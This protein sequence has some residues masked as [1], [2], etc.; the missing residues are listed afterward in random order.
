MRL[1]HPIWPPALLAILVLMVF[2]DGFWGV[3]RA[4]QL[5]YLYEAAQFPRFID[6]LAHAP[7]WNRS[8]SVGDY[9]LFRPILYL[10]LTVEYGLFG[11]N[12]LLWQ[13]TGIALHAA[14]SVALLRLFQ[15]ASPATT[16]LNLIA[17]GLFA[18]LLISSEAVIWH[19]ISA[20]IL[21]ALCTTGS[22]LCLLRYLETNRRRSA[23]VAVLLAIVATFTYELG[24]VYCLLVAVSLT[25]SAG[26]SLVT[27]QSDP[28]HPP[29]AP[30]ARRTLALVFAAIPV[31]YVAVSLA[32]FLAQFRGAPALGYGPG[33]SP[34]VG[35]GLAFA[36]H[37]I[38]FWLGGAILPTVYDITWGGGRS[39]FQAYRWSSE[40]LTLLNL[41]VVHITAV[42][43]L[44]W[45]LIGRRHL[46]PAAA[47]G[48]ALGGSLLFAYS[49]IISFGRSVP[50]GLLTLAINLH[51]A[52]IAMVLLAATI[53]VALWMNRTAPR[54]E[55][56]ARQAG[57]PLALSRRLLLVGL[58][59][60]L[61]VNGVATRSLLSD[62]RRVYAARVME[63]LH[64]ARK[65][66]ETRSPGEYFTVAD[67]CPGNHVLTWFEPYIRHDTDTVYFLDTLYPATSANLH[68]EA[69]ARP[70]AR[71]RAL[72]CTEDPLNPRVLLG[73]WKVRGGSAI[74]RVAADGRVELLDERG[75]ASEVAAQGRLLFAAQWKVVGMVAH[76]DRYIFWGDGRT[77]WR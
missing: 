32:D 73:T 16:G 58:V 13:A 1:A 47:A 44:G 64:H 27:A 34:E 3:P 55:G 60:L 36:V 46:R 38:W 12:F 68:R 8:V 25:L 63:L 54:R 71:V 2:Y 10:F 28:N 19:H 48:V 56:V 77:W 17:A 62:Y 26:R 35:R 42:G 30:R 23:D 5:I 45:I 31:G 18:S 61:L 76:D 65:W 14:E 40:P 70:G 51:Y 43:A 69:A 22:L 29:V 66:H 67:G 37:Q 33:L 53:A 57:S 50:R 52:Y 21:F 39:F 9:L 11:H 59:G 20:Y 75:L 72:S 4:D 49:C 74:G 41:A 24:T 7:S 15:R 6:L